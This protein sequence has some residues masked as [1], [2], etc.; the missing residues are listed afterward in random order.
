M[1]C[2]VFTQSDLESASG[3][4]SD[5]ITFENLLWGAQFDITVFIILVLTYSMV[6]MVVPRFLVVWMA[7]FLLKGIGLYEW[8]YRAIW[9]D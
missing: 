5:M 7:K 9:G 3:A 8:V 2:Q 1:V 4:K 6:K